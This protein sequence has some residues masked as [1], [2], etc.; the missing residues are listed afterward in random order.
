MRRVA[1]LVGVCALALGSVALAACGRTSMPPQ[2]QPGLTTGL[3]G[4][5]ANLARFLATRHPA[6]ALPTFRF[7]TLPSVGGT[8]CFVSSATHACS[9]TPCKG[10]VAA[11]EGPDWIP[12]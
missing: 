4:M 9:M 7:R 6:L 10:F 5:K 3:T 1:V 2:R 11:S 12:L 8:T